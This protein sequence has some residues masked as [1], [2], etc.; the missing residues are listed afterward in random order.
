MSLIISEVYF[1]QS[2]Y[3]LF[4][5]IGLAWIYPKVEFGVNITPP[6][7]DFY[8]KGKIKYGEFLAGMGSGS[9]IFTY[10]NL[11]NLKAKRKVP[12]GID[13]GVGI[14]IRKSKLH[15]TLDWH[16]KVSFYDRIVIPEIVSEN[17]EPL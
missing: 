13:F 14:P 4:W 11:K 15:V 10:A 5:K 1:E 3:G 7:I 6:Y 2:S 16:N 17:E 8:S 9:D 12:F